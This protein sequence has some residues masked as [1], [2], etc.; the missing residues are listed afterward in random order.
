MTMIDAWAISFL[1]LLIYSAH[2]LGRIEEYARFIAGQL[3]RYQRQT[4]V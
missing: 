2:K 1:M 4:D 3:E